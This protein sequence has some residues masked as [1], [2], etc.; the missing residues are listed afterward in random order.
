M[1]R[2]HRRQAVKRGI[3]GPYTGNFAIV[4][5]H[6]LR[7]AKLSLYTRHP[8]SSTDDSSRTFS[9]W[10]AQRDFLHR[11]PA[12]SERGMET[13]NCYVF[14]TIY[15]FD[16]YTSQ[17]GEERKSVAV[18]NES[19]T[20]V[21]A[22]RRNGNGVKSVLIAGREDELEQNAFEGCDE[23]Q[24]IRQVIELQRLTIV[25]DERSFI[26]ILRFPSARNASRSRIRGWNAFE[27][28]E[29]FRSDGKSPAARKTATKKRNACRPRWAL[30][31]VRYRRSYTVFHR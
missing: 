2:F 15:P 11:R 23:G 20:R 27:L 28:S 4:L 31:V 29:T 10:D 7:A 12:V 14:A 21:T 19:R 25:P 30:R 1:L 6:A 22:N 24:R 5:P 18:K 13:T 17:R 9:S 16:E 3:Y 8:L 26:N